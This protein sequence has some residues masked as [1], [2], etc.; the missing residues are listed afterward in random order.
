MRGLE[1][2]EIHE[3]AGGDGFL[4]YFAGAIGGAIGAAIGATL[5]SVVG[6]DAYLSQ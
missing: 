5:G 6:A 3:V 4:G 1:T 2:R